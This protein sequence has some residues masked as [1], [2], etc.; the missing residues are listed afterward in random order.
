VLHHNEIFAFLA[1]L[2][3]LLVG[4][5]KWGR[6]ITAGIPMKYSNEQ[7][8]RE[9]DIILLKN[10]HLDRLTDTYVNGIAD[11][12]VEIVSPESAER[13]YGAKFI[14][15]EAAGVPEYWRVDPIRTHAVVYAL[16]EDGRYHPL[17]LD[18]QGRLV[19]QVLPGFALDPALLWGERL[20]DGM[21]LVELAQGMQ[22]VG[23]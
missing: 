6:V 15:Y 9:P 20:P 22:E 21:E 10:E 1:A 8:A 3:R 4:M 19:S 2:L 12:V 18:A 11:I 14:E 7:P 17:P 16:G 13:D 23:E 5:H